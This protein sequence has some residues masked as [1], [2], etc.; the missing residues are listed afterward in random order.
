MGTLSLG[1]TLVGVSGAVFGLV[2]GAENR[3]CKNLL[4]LALLIGV[5][6]LTAFYVLKGFRWN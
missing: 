2:T 6:S 1:I 3:E 5:A 4:V